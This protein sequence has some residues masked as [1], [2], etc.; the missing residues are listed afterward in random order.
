M[1]TTNTISTDVLVDR[2][3]RFANLLIDIVAIFIFAFIATIIVT[4]LSLIVGNG[5]AVWL[6]GMSDAEANILGVV[7]MSIY[8][9]AMELTTGRTI[10][11][12]ITGTLIVMEDGTK[13]KARAVVIRTLCRFLPFEVFSFFGSYPRGWHDSAAGIYVVNAKKFNAALQIKNSFSEIGAV[14]DI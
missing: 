6:S 3:V 7:I 5:L 2:P 4:L 10:G 14:Q 12:Y 11:K 9:I 8:Y 1:A 13:P